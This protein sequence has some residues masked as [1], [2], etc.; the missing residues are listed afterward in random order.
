MS[1]ECIF[2]QAEGGIHDHALSR[3]LGDVYKRQRERFS[4]AV[5]WPRPCRFDTADGLASSVPL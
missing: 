2:F 1:F 3:G 5:R 4:R